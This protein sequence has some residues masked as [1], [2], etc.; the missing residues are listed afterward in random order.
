LL[1][2]QGFFEFARALAD[3]ILRE[4][5]G[6]DAERIH[7]AFRL[8]L[9]RQPNTRERQTL[10]RL[11]ARLGERESI[12]AWTSIARVLLNLDEFITRE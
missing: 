10:E 11:L 7:Y 5:K 3:R 8:C 1:N 12:D 4:S 2:D 6:E 9:G